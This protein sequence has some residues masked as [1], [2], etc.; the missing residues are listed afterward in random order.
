MEAGVSDARRVGDITQHV[1]AVKVICRKM[2]ARGAMNRWSLDEAIE[3]GMALGFEWLDRYYDPKRGNVSTFLYRTLP[4]RLVALYQ[5]EQGRGEKG[6]RPESVELDVE[7]MIDQTTPLDALLED[8]VRGQVV[9]DAGSMMAAMCEGDRGDLMAAW[10]RAGRQHGA[11]SLGIPH[12]RI[13][14]AVADFRAE[15]GLERTRVYW[16]GV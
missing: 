13:G 10:V 15:M 6:L 7:T 5:Y 1:G 4:Q 16:H 2:K 3:H 11:R 8:E 12:H 9:R 14:G